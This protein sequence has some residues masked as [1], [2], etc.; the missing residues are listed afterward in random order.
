LVEGDT[1]ETYDVFM[2]D[3]CAGSTTRVSVAADGSEANRLSPF[4]RLSGDGAWVAFQSRATNLSA[5]DGNSRYDVFLR[6]PLS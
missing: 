3:T 2:R 6:G 4:G 5:E 1:N